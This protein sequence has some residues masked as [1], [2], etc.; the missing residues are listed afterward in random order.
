MIW[1]DEG[2]KSGREVEFEIAVNFTAALVL[3]ARLWPIGME[4]S[5]LWL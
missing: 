3:R 5:G 2:R 4:R 1:R